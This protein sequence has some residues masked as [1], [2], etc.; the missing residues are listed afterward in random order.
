MNFSLKN[1]GSA[2]F[3]S[4]LSTTFGLLVGSILCV[5]IVMVIDNGS[6]SMSSQLS[7][8]IAS[9]IAISVGTMASKPQSFARWTIYLTAIVAGFYL[10]LEQSGM[11]E[12]T[13][14]ILFI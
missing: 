1:E 11:M 4:I 5:I 13:L 6:Y 8:G 2:L 3:E 10:A 12:R 14:K 7:A 9:I